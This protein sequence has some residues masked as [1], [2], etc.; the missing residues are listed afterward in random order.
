ME[1]V[2]PIRAYR[3]REGISAT[4][5]A[6]RLGVARNTIWRWES[7]RQQIVREL[8]NKIHSETGIPIDQLA[9]IRDGE[10]A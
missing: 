7:G 4:A 6:K 1:L 5:L 8:W 9:G 2:H 3:D 10:A